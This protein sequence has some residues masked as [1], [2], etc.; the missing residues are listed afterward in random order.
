MLLNCHLLPLE[1]AW[2]WFSP[3]N[4]VLSLLI[5]GATIGRPRVV[6]GADPY[7]KILNTAQPV[8]DDVLGV[9]FLI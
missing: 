7:R 6:E 5:V 2:L 8:G 3:Y 1:K 4:L 9:P